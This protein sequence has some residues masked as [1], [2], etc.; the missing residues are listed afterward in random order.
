PS[1]WLLRQIERRTYE[2]RTF[3]EELKAMVVDIVN[4]VL[5][6]NSNRRVTI[7]TEETLKEAMA[8]KKAARK[9]SAAKKS[10]APKKSAKKAAPAIVE[11]AV[12]PLC[13]KGKIIRGRTAF[14]CS[15]WK[16]GCTFRAPLEQ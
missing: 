9:S 2:A 8:K 12:C 16:A 4:K 15:E 11:G 6:D 3:L 5:A 1:R 14:G 13:G 7:T 10:S